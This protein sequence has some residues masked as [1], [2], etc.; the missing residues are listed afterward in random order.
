MANA[1]T[2]TVF[3]LQ[4]SAIVYVAVWIHLMNIETGFLS[5]RGSA[6][7]SDYRNSWKVRVIQRSRRL[8]CVVNLV[9]GDPQLGLLARSVNI[10]RDRIRR[11]MILE[12]ST[13]E[14]A[15]KAFQVSD[16]LLN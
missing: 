7:Y 5:C 4:R 3:G 15:L 12:T 16:S 10:A 6:V 11:H 8:N 14:D 2:L 1:R 9:Q 13:P